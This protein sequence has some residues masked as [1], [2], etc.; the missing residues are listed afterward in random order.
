[1]YIHTSLAMYVCVLPAHAKT[2]GS[3]NELRL[4]NLLLLFL[5]LL[6]L[7]LTARQLT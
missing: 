1:M 3:A 7:L 5:L 6:L 2:N 4:A